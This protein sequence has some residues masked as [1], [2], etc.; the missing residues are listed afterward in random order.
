MIQQITFDFRNIN[1]VQVFYRRFSALMTLDDDF[2][3]NLDA[4]WDA[5]TGQVALP[6][7]VTLRYLHQHPD[8]QQFNPLIELL[9]DAEDE[10]EGAFRVFITGE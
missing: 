2:G 1:N 4:L 7:H 5:I 8:A 3:N 6:L 10:T 9:H